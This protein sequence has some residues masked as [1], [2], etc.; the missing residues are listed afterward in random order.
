MDLISERLLQDEKN[1]I[2]MEV[3]E[4]ATNIWLFNLPIIRGSS[5]R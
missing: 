3:K 4:I 5:L 1:V 2:A